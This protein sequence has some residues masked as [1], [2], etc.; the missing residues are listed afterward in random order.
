MVH[1]SQM[2]GCYKQLARNLVRQLGA[3]AL[4]LGTLGRSEVS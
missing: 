3:S 1:R 2:G 4:L